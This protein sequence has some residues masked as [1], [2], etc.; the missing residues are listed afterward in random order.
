MTLT[1]IIG[2]DG[3]EANESQRVGIGEY[4]F[5]LIK[6]F[7]NFQFPISNFQFIIYVKNKPINDLPKERPGWKYRIVGPKKLWTQIG[8]PIDLFLHSPR[9][10]VFFTPTHYA[11]RFSPVP[12][13]IS[14]MDLSFLHFPELFKQSDLFQ[15]KNWTRYSV[16]KAKKIFT[17]SNASKGDIIKQYGVLEDKVVVTYPGIKFK[18]QNSK[19]K[20]TMQKSKVLQE[21]FNIKKNYILF[22]GTLQPRKNIVRLIEA[23][24]LLDKKDIDLVIVG[25]KGWLYEEILDA[26]RKFNVEQ[27]VKFLDFATDKELAQL[28]KNALFFVLPS[29][30]EGFGLPVLEAMKYSC[31][32]ITSNVSSLPEA[33]GNAALYVNPLDTQDIKEKMALLLNNVKLRSELIEKGKIQVEKFS[34]EKTARLTLTVLEQIVEEK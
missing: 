12:C 15:L 31:P 33:G 11:P 8:L 32:V 25:K 14:V 2:I 21:R 4:A 23:F 27:S 7:E 29:L 24:S 10:D 30:Y 20:I 34:W 5:E 9:S 16:K 1:M 18:I 22:V 28:Y 13:A 3:N 26:P 6:Q 17:I 19:F